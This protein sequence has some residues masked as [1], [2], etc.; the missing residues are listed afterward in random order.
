M[1]H[2]K[3]KRLTK[4]PPIT[5]NTSRLSQDDTS[6]TKLP[7]YQMPVTEA[8][9]GR[10][11]ADGRKSR[12]VS[13]T[14]ANY[15]LLERAVTRFDARFTLRV[16]R[17]ISSIR[18]HLSSDPLARVFTETYPATISTAKALLAAIGKEDASFDSPATSSDME[19]PEIPVTEQVP[20]RKGL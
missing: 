8:E 19:R 2:F 11:E 6:T 17:S 3:P 9:A 10:A 18:K 16:L 4:Q 15:A 12:A 5:A 7:F 1:D 14:K 20:S 13:D